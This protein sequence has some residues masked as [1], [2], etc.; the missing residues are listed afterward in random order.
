MGKTWVESVVFLREAIGA[1][2]NGN[3]T[4]IAD[5]VSKVGVPLVVLL[6]VLVQMSPRVD[7]L[8]DIANQ[9]EAELRY[10]AIKGCAPSAV[11]TS[12]FGLSSPWG[13]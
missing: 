1:A 2:V 12:P 7:R 13:T 8:I 3:V 6:I 4:T 9:Q 10:L 5:L 11:T